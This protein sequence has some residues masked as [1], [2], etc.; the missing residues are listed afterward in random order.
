MMLAVIGLIGCSD[1]SNKEPSLKEQV[2]E[3]EHEL[4]E[5]KKQV[6]YYKDQEEASKELKPHRIDLIDPNTSA[7]VKTLELKDFSYETDIETYI[8]EIEKLAKDLAR[9]TK[10]E[11][12]YDQKMILDRLDENGQVIKGRPMVVLKES[13]LVEEILAASSTGGSI[14]LPLKVSESGYKAEDLQYLHEAVIGSYTTYFN[15]ADIGR[16]KNIELSAQAIHNTIVGNLDYFSF[17]VMVGPR[18]EERGYQP[19]PEIINAKRVMGIGGG[20]CQTSSTLF[21]AIDQVPVTFVERHHHSLNVGYVPKG[22][23]ATVAY[24]SLDFRFQNTSGVPLLI[25]AIYGNGYLTIEIRTSNEYEILLD[26]L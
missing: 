17:N 5:L 3:L 24:D 15:G 2:T 9:G 26:A 21:N 19:A 16:S 12:G 1:E 13:Q 10:T 23:D 4:K 25:K 7:I 14:E 18:T 20:I 8:D 6:A 22:R 11:V